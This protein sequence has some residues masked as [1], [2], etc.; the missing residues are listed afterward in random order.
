MKYLIILSLGI[1]ININLF[2][3]EVTISGEQIKATS[4]THTQ[5]ISNTIKIK[6]SMKIVKVEGNCTAFWIQKT[7]IT[8]HKFNKL[9]KCIG[10]I[11]KPG[12]YTIYPELK[13]GQDT[14][15]IKITLTKHKFKP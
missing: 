15:T 3:Q 12:K 11:L 10:I 1:L 5:L 14:A 2:S 8:I 7:N 4:K 6:T 9:E 13:S